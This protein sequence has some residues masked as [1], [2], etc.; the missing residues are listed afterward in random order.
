V[1]VDLLAPLTLCVVTI[2]NDLSY[3]Q[4]PLVSLL[5]AHGNGTQLLCKLLLVCWRARVVLFVCPFWTH[6]LR[7]RS[8]HLAEIL[9]TGG[10]RSVP[11][12]ASRI[13]VAIVPKSPAGGGG[14]AQI[15]FLRLTGCALFG[16]CYF[17]FVRQMAA[18]WH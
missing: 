14:G 6:L 10:W 17:I 8:T 5:S 18:Q 7:N 2:A 1:V 16:S 3:P 15:W 9:H 4:R 12:T 11:D 13:L